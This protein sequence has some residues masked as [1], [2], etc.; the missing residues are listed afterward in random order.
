M[1]A[2]CHPLSYGLP[3]PLWRGLPTV[4]RIASPKFWERGMTQPFGNGDLR[5][6]RVGTV[7]RP[8]L[9]GGVPQRRGSEAQIHGGTTWTLPS[10]VHGKLLVC[11]KEGAA[12]C[13]QL[14]E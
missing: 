6:G 7:G 3:T 4:P 2:P 11:N 5:S 14:G 10:L 13:V 9:N 12:V 1:T 8:C